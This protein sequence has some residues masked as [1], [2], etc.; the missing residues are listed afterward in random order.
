MP[1]SLA[2]GESEATVIRGKPSSAGWPPCPETTA[3]GTPGSARRGGSYFSSLN[4]SCT[5][6]GEQRQGTWSP[7]CTG[8][9]RG[10]HSLSRYSG[11]RRDYNGCD[12]GATYNCPIP[13]QG[14]WSR[15]WLRGRSRC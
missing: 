14:L 6:R 15:H 8:Q 2:D 5:H 11:P 10:D 1:R 7:G 13:M 4:V 12:T 9:R 3:C